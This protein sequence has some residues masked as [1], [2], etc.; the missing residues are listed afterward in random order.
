M[1]KN[2]LTREITLTHTPTSFYLLQQNPDA[3]TLYHFY[4]YTASWQ[5]EELV[6]ATASFVM[7]ALHWGE[8]RYLK[9]KK[10]LVESKIVS[11]E[12]VKGEDG[13]ITGNY[14]LVRTTTPP[15][16]GLVH[17]GTNNTIIKESKKESKPIIKTTEEAQK[18]LG[19]SDSLEE[20]NQNKLK[21][22]SFIKGGFGFQTG[23]A[24]NTIGQFSRKGGVVEYGRE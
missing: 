7:K 15:N 18:V 20:Y 8:D 13:K 14:I 4:C 6:Y 1:I 12:Q 21:R 11:N 10:V 22:K 24:K 3:F 9:A 16:G 19:N 5:Q 17:K 2:E 23:S